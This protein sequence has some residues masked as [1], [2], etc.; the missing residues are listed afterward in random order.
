M[1]LLEFGTCSVTGLCDAFEDLKLLDSSKHLYAFILKATRAI[2]GV[3]HLIFEQMGWCAHTI[4]FITAQV[5]SLHGGIFRHQATF[6][7]F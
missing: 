6:Q 1:S 7:K 2:N 3:G 4:S 5:V